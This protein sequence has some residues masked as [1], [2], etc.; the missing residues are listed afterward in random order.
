MRELNDI[1]EEEEFKL[2]TLKS[3]RLPQV[4]LHA[5]RSINRG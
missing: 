1:E 2:L 5:W 3:T 4:A